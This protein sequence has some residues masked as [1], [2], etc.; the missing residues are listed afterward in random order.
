MKRQLSLTCSGFTW[1]VEEDF[2]TVPET[3]IAA[4]G[5]KHVNG[6]PAPDEHGHI[7]GEP[8]L[9]QQHGLQPGFHTSRACSLL[10]I[11]TNWWATVGSKSQQRA[12]EQKQMDVF[13]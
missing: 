2:K 4:H 13:W 1:N 7:P 5:V 6:Q 10:F 8:T 3:W 12:S 9:T 11:K